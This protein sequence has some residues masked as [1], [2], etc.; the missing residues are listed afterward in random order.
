MT[1]LPPA[2]WY[3]DPSDSRGQRWWDGQQWGP[4]APPAAASAPEPSGGFIGWYLRTTERLGWK[5]RRSTKLWALVAAV[6]ILL[7]FMSAAIAGVAEEEAGSGGSG[8]TASDDRAPGGG[9]TT[10]SSDG[11][12]D[13]DRERERTTVGRTA[14]VTRVIDGDTIV[15][16]GLGSTRLIGVDTPEEGQCGDNAATRFTRS[17][18]DGRTVGYVIGEEPTDR[19]DR[20]LA[21]VYRGREMHNLAL[22]QG[23]YAK[24]LTIAPNDRF[25]ARFKQAERQAKRRDV[26]QWGICAR[27]PRPSRPSRPHPPQREQDRQPAPS[28]AAPIPENCSGVAGPIPTPPGDPTGL[29]GNNDGMACE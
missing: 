10:G 9:G 5:Q 29:D 2:G 28:V 4:V 11:D 12:G 14:R 25:A 19:Y 26:G 24:V 7:F 20:T 17:R 8:D 27:R 13:G 18:L 23:G 6:P 3:S 21:Y 16:A 22:L 1:T 15:I